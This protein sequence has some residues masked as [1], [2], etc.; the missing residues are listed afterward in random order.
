MKIYLDDIRNPSDT[1][2]SGDT[3]V[4]CR[5][6]DEFERVLFENSDEV[7]VISFDHDLGVDETG[8]EV[9]SGYD[10]V[11]IVEK[12]VYEGVMEPPE[13]RVHS[14]NPVGR[15]RI[16]LTIDAMLNRRNEREY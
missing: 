1:Y 7:E 5:S 4:L 15:R 11:C 3:W 9:R 16:E 6:V 8:E 13:M 10:A 12:L 2:P 14:A